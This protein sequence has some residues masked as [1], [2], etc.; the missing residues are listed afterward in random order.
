MV[1]FLSIH[2]FSHISSIFV[3]FFQKFPFFCVTLYLINLKFPKLGSI[4]C[5]SC[6]GCFG[7]KCSDCELQTLHACLLKYLD[8]VHNLVTI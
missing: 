1:Q 6:Q 7:V 5:I 2:F 8:D 4:I 3:G